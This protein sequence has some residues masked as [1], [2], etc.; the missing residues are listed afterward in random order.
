MRCGFLGK[1]ANKTE[2]LQAFFK[3]S[4]LGCFQTKNNKITIGH[5]LSQNFTE[6]IGISRFIIG[7]NRKNPVFLLKFRQI[8]KQYHFPYIIFFVLSGQRYFY[9][10]NVT[11]PVKIKSGG[12]FKHFDPDI[13]GGRVRFVAINRAFCMFRTSFT[14]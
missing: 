6:Q 4:Y 7:F 11:S 14:L 9:K 3:H 2:K 1:I 10:E 13:R 12:C 5:Q 8:C